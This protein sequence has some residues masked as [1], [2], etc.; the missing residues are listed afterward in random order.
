[1]TG[2]LIALAGVLVACA[3]VVLAERKIRRIRRERAAFAA[4][5]A[6]AQMDQWQAAG[7]QALHRPPT[8]LDRILAEHE[9]AEEALRASLAAEADS[10]ADLHD[11]FPEE[12]D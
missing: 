3:G 7:A 5:R 2:E 9:A 10:Y 8:R 1:M 4:I 6:R 11:V 12:R